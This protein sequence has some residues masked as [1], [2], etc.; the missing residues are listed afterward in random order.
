MLRNPSVSRALAGKRADSPDPSFRVRPRFQTVFG[1][2][3][4][5][6]QMTSFTRLVLGSGR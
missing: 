3:E 5:I 6:Q 1:N 2:E 4:R